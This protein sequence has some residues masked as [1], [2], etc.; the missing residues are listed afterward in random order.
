MNGASKEWAER[1]AARNAIETA[2]ARR[3]HVQMEFLWNSQ[4]DAG[5]GAPSD[6][7]QE[8]GAL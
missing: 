6:R 2:K 3:E 4:Q 7:K 8:G 5:A 1:V